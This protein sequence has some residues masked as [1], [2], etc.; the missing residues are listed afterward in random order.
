MS[1]VAKMLEVILNDV[2][3]TDD[4]RIDL[5]LETPSICNHPLFV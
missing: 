5:L 1:D 3:M 4:E 2:Q